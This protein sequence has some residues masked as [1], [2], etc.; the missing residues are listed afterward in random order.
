MPKRQVLSLI[1]ALAFAEVCGADVIT[2]TDGKAWA[3]AVDDQFHTITFTELGGQAFL[4]DQYADFGVLFPEPDDFVDDSPAFLNDGW[5]A[6]GFNPTITVDFA[7][8]VHWVAIDYPGAM[9]IR[10]YHDGVLFSS[11][12]FPSG[13]AFAGVISTDP[14]DRVVFLDPLG[15]VAID[16]LHIPLIPA[17]TT[18]WVV[19]LAAAAMGR[20]RPH[21]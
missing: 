21:H 8:D 5:G 1:L 4:S 3:S 15:S 7:H 9:I 20:R 19:G 18:L 11:T 16:D 14:V 10:L 17:P 13:H 6:K 2:F 12:P